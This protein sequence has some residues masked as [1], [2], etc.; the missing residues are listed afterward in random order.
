[1]LT[2]RR[3]VMLL[4]ATVATVALAG[5]GREPRERLQGKWRGIGVEGLA[6]EQDVKAEGWAKGTRFEF[7]GNKVTVSMPAESPRS[8]T[9]RVAQADGDKLKLQFKRPEGG[10]DLADFKFA[11]DG[12][13]RWMVGDA[14]VVMSKSV[15]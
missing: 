8:G 2:R 15:D 3:A 9:Y 6:G 12:T 7:V 11:K 13:L 1:M 4:V 5:C 10:E 14:Q